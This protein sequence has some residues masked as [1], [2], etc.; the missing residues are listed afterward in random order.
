MSGA[1][2]LRRVHPAVEIR[3]QILAEPGPIELVGVM[4]NSD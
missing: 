3:D 4:H 1:L 2:E